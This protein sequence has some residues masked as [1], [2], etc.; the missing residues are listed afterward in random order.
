MRSRTSTGLRF[1][2]ERVH[3]P[4]LSNHASPKTCKQSHT[5]F[6]ITAQSDRLSSSGNLWYSAT[7]Y[8]RTSRSHDTHV[9]AHLRLPPNLS[10]TIDRKRVP[11]HALPTPGL[12]TTSFNRGRV[13]YRKQLTHPNQAMSSPA[14]V[15]PPR[16]TGQYWRASGAHLWAD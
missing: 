11:R 15:S 6:T 1:I 3:H 5:Q 13:W 9:G 16:K 4:Q 12:I 8:G 7:W 14:L 10:L 2:S